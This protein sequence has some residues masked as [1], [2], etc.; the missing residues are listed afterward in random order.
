MYPQDTT[1][2]PQ[3]QPIPRPMTTVGK[4][5]IIVGAG[6]VAGGAAMMAHGNEGCAGTCIDWTAT[7]AVWAGAGAALL[8][9]GLVK[10]R[11]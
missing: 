9:I 6:S 5:L 7:G 1:Q 10:L 4:A 11:Q 2:A 3:Q 8:V